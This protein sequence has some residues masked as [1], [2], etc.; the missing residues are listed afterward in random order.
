MTV[1]VYCTI[2]YNSH[3]ILKLRRFLKLFWNGQWTLKANLKHNKKGHDYILSLTVHAFFLVKMQE[4]YN[5]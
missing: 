3:I 1:G 5:N 2:T 4:Y